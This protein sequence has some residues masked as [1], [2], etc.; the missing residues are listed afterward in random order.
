MRDLI[1]VFSI[2]LALIFLITG[3]SRALRY[4]QTRKFFAWVNDVP[5][6]LVQV[7][8]FVEILGAL[9][10][11]LPVATGI[12]PWLTLVAAGALALLLVLAILFHARRHEG[13]EIGAPVLLLLM[14]AFVAYGRWALGQVR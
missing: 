1:W 14:I 9:G 6:P 10:L 8:G 3:V 7:I 11:I 4:Q 12:Y 2:V 13:S 5:R